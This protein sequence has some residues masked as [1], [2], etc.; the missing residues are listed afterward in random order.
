MEFNF[1]NCRHSKPWPCLLLN[2]AK[3]NGKRSIKSCA[4]VLKVQVVRVAWTRLSVSSSFT[5]Q[6]KCRNVS[7]V[8]QPALR[9]VEA[10][11]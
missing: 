9:A 2:D 4:C 1:K 6:L 5:P 8:S 10:C 11:L 7:G 3:I